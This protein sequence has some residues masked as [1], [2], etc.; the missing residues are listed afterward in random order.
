MDRTA[1]GGAASG[2]EG[3]VR[4]A[5][6]FS[7]ITSDKLRH[8]FHQWRVFDQG[9]VCW[10]TRR[11]LQEWTGPRSL[12][13]PVLVSADPTVLAEKPYL[14]EWLGIRTGGSGMEPAEE[15]LAAVYRDM[16]LPGTAR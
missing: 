5:A 1:T 10:A 16:L 14:R 7:E 15:E 12:I 13:Q 8:T 4:D 3:G 2:Q 6:S 11:S 9:G